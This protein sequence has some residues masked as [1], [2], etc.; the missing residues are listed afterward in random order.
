M[1]NLCLAHAHLR[2]VGTHIQPWG[3]LY[4]AAS[5]GARAEAA[6]TVHPRSTTRKKESRHNLRTRKSL[7]GSSVAE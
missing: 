1:F 4:T 3:Q 2:T 6:G 5:S 7:F